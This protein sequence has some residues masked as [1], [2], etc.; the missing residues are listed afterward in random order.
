VALKAGEYQAHHPP[1]P[2]AQILRWIRELLRADDLERYPQ[3]R[4]EGLRVRREAL[5]A[6]LQSLKDAGASAL[7]YLLPL[8]TRYSWTAL[9]IPDILLHWGDDASIRALVDM[10]LFHY[11]F[12]SESCLKALEQ[13]GERALPH[14]K[15]AFHK[16]REFDPLK[17]GLISVAGKMATPE[18]LAWVATLLGHPEPTVVNWA[19]GV[20]AEAGYVNALER[21]KEAKTR[22][23][24]EPRLEWAIEQLDR[25]KAGGRLAPNLSGGP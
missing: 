15:E 25:L 6:P 22:I 18:A 8:C 2:D 19:G 4:E 17:I 20:L 16:D 5:S 23:G 9:L 11:P 3:L 21:I 12:L 24:P 13:L 14:I 10:T 1:E 7:P